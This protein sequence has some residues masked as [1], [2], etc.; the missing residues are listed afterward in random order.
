MFF[1]ALRNLVH[2]PPDGITY[3]DVEDDLFQ[4]KQAQHLR[5]RAKHGYK[6]AGAPAA[7][8]PCGREG[9]RGALPLSRQL[10]AYPS[11]PVIEAAD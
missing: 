10:K 7:A 3:D 1:H 11:L 6:C 5:K 4:A 8:G 2:P 9:A